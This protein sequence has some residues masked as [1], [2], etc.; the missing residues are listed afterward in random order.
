MA[1]IRSFEICV[2]VVDPAPVAA[3]WSAFLGYSTTDDPNDRWVHLEP[4]AGL[5]VINLQRV[6]EAKTLKNRLHFDVYV[7]EPQE[8]IDRAKE[9][10]AT[11]QRL[12]D[13]PDDWFMVLHDPGGNEFCICQER[14]P[15]ACG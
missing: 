13:S 5:P 10:G 2:D 3:F 1:P 15:G 12:H 14:L 9:F 6:P 8:W 7:D 4:P 11:E